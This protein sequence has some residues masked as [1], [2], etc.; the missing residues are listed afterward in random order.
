MCYGAKRPRFEFPWAKLQKLQY[1]W[2]KNDTARRQQNTT[3][4]AK[5]GEG[6]EG[7]WMVVRGCLSSAAIVALSKVRGI[8]NSSK[9][10]SVVA[11]NLLV[12]D[13][14]PNVKNV[15]HK[16]TEM[17]KRKVNKK[18]FDDALE[19]PGQSGDLWKV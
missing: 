3:S 19:G 12:F 17:N 6:G 13:K 15:I 14:G 1:A 5:D 10:E 11:Q 18:R 2:L 7:R 16:N 8:G 4:T 9:Y